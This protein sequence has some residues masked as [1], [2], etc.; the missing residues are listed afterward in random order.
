MSI[1]RRKSSEPARDESGSPEVVAHD[2]AALDEMAS[3]EAAAGDLVE[4]FD[5]E[6]EVSDRSQGPWDRS[7]VD[8][9]GDRLDLGAVWIAPLDGAELRLEVDAATDTVSAIQLV[10]PQTS[11][12]AQ[13]QAFAAPRS[14]GVWRDVRTEIADAITAA[15]GTAETVDGVFG[16]ELNVRMPQAGPDGRTVFAPARFVGVDGPRWFLRAVL[17]GQAAVEDDAAAQLIEGIRSLVVVRG[18]DP[19]APREMLALTLPEAPAEPEPEA[20]VS[21]EDADGPDERYTNPD[22]NPFERG[23]EITEVR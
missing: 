21:E 22:L 12:A 19:M 23:P 4:E 14:G 3:G 11:S 7:E 5:D 15:G 6:P 13:I 16:P 10:I 8:G 17:S 20:A 18:S 2:D 1:F 9:L